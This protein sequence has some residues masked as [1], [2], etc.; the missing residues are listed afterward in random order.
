MATISPDV[1]DVA[2]D[3]ASGGRA[4]CN[5]H[6]GTRYSQASS[7]TI[8]I[9]ATTGTFHDPSIVAYIVDMRPHVKHRTFPNIN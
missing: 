1:D 8:A 2:Q 9:L 5:T 3:G 7:A 6:V 4:F